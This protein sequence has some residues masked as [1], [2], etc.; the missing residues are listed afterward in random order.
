MRDPVVMTPHA[1]PT[2]TFA[3]VS[4]VA[5][6]LNLS[7]SG[8]RARIKRG[9]LRPDAVTDQGAALFDLRTLDRVDARPLETR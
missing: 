2:P 7:E 1:S 8:V 4:T 3:T 5:R 9:D 6:R